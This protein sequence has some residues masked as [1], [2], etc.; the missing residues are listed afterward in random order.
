MAAGSPAT[1]RSTGRLSMITPVEN[2]STCS[3]AICSSPA[4]ATQVARARARPSAPVPAL[5]L[6]VLTTIARGPRAGRQVGTTELYRRGTEAI[7]GEHAGD[8]RAGRDRDHGEVTPVG[9]AD[10]RHRDAEF[11]PRHRV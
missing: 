11:D 7:G 4:S 9:L 3:G 1:M 8:G 6:P 5:A 10:T 2:G